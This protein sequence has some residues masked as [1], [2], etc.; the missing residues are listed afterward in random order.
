MKT[1]KFTLLVDSHHGQYMPQIFA[2][3]IN[4]EDWNIRPEDLAILKSGPDNDDN[5]TAWGPITDILENQTWDHLY[6]ETWD[7]VSGNTTYFP[8]EDSFLCFGEGAGDLF[9]VSHSFIESELQAIMEKGGYIGK[10]AEEYIVDCVN[11]FCSEE[12]TI[13]F[14]RSSFESPYNDAKVKRACAAIHR[15]LKA[16]VL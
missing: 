9:L 13:E 10:I 1:L 16:V 15:H 14:F 4:P 11:E 6:D 2:G 8:Y 7:Y 5:V 3:M 12:E